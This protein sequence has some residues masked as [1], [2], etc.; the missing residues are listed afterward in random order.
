V[1]ENRTLFSFQRQ[2]R[3]S[4]ETGLSQ[5]SRA[6][7]DRDGECGQGKQREY[8]AKPGRGDG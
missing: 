4:G 2:D 5:F 3:R 6:G 1:V 8:G 7:G